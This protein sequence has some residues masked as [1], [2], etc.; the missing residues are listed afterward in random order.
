MRP[1]ATIV[2]DRHARRQR[3]ERILEHDLQILAQRPHLVPR[4]RLDVVAEKDDAALRRDQPEQRAAERR[5]ARTGLADDAERLACADGEADVVDRL[6]VPDCAAQ[7]A[8]LDRE[9]DPQLIGRDDDRRRCIGHRRRTA[10]LGRQQ[11]LGVVVLRGGEDCLG[12]ALFDDLAIGH[13]ADAVGHLA[14]DAE[15][16]GDEQ[17]R[18]AQPRLQRLEQ[19][20]DLRLHCDVERGGR[21][22]G[23]QQVRLVGE[24]HGDH[25]ALALAARELVRVGVEPAFG[26]GNAD[27]LEQLDGA[28]A[29]RGL[30]QAAMRDQHLAHLVLDGVERI[31][32]A[33]RLL[34]DHRDVGAAHLAHL[35]VARR[36]EVWPLKRSCRR[37]VPRR[38]GAAGSRPPSPTCPSRIRRPAPKSA[39]ARPRTRCRAPRVRH[40]RRAG[41]RW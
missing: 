13:D 35:A 7:H 29:R 1:S 41:N 31:E 36:C 33:H 21:L 25:H 8:A 11:L 6:H 34:E 30:A 16:V 24:R 39:S 5:L 27:I 9:P 2:A 32:R 38:E 20:Q 12:R 18:H 28:G 10:R 4:A 40:A 15:I 23:D 37:S 22:V 17:H 3:S 26:I 19:R 14:H